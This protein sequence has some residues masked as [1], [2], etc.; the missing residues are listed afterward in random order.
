MKRRVASLLGIV[1][2]GLSGAYLAVFGWSVLVGPLAGAFL[3]GFVLAAILMIVGGFVDSVTVGGRDVPWNVFVGIGDVVLAAVVTL[4]AVRSAVVTADTE[5]RLFAAA[6]L[7]G[8][9]SLA[10][11]GVQT[12]RNSRHVDFEGTPSSRRLAGIA[13]L[14]AVSFGIGLFVA[15]GV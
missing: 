3:V 6:T 14:V 2:L 9:T 4:S 13:L 11:L 5:S 8:C 15:T 12:A 10:W 1:M 7:V